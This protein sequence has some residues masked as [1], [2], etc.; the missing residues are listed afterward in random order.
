MSS[1]L[2]NYYEKE[3]YQ[4]TF[5]EWLTYEEAAIKDY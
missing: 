5:D 1:N 3:I 2:K 4:E